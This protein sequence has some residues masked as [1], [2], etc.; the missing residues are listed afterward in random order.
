EY[1]VWP[2]AVRSLRHEPQTRRG[3]RETSLDGLVTNAL[4]DARKAKRGLRCVS[5]WVEQGDGMTWSATRV[6]RRLRQEAPEVLRVHL[7]GEGTL[8]SPEIARVVTQ[9]T[10]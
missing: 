1:P 2:R 4:A 6:E 5:I 9:K 7:K 10:F 3:S 8:E